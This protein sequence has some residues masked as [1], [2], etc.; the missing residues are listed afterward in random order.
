MSTTRLSV[1]ITT[2]NRPASLN[3]CLTSLA[4]IAH[5][6]PDV[7][8]FDDG[9]APPV[10]Q[11][12]TDETRGIV[13]QVLRDPSTPGP[14]AGRNRLVRN[15]SGSYVLLMDDDAR[16]ID[17]AAVERAI[18]VLDQDRSVAAIGFAQ[19]EVDGRPWPA[20]MQPSPAAGP[21]L[22]PCYIGFAH[23]VRRQTF[24]DLG[25][26]REAFEFYGEEKDFGVRVLDAGLSVV[27]LPSALVVHAS[28][29]AGRDARRYLRQVARNDCLT[30]L[31]NDPLPRVL[32]MTAARYAL[33]FRMR[34][35]WR[36]RDPWGGV[37]LARDLVRRLPSVLSQRRPVK[38]RTIARWAE[39]KKDETPYSEPAA[40]AGSGL[41]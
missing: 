21:A 9:S 30:S 37:W 20:A 26:Y 17:A 4:V 19:A 18:G 28:D 13:S 23:L 31:Y 35:K 3:A 14:I 34:H 32:W 22:V 27:Y 38:R 11:Q 41:S 25:G 10:E 36:I 6:S 8:V 5:L 12:F 24:L 39:L 1:G 15:A 7:L 2:R 16:L 40:D 29:P 33:Y